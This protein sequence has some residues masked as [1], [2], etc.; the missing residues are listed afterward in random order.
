MTSWVRRSPGAGRRG[1]GG[2]PQQPRG[3]WPNVNSS[4]CGAEEPLQSP[5]VRRKRIH[6]GLKEEEEERKNGRAPVLRVR[7]WGGRASLS[8]SHRSLSIADSQRW[9][10]DAARSRECASTPA[11]LSQAKHF[12]LLCFLFQRPLANRLCQPEPRK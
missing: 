6:P 3:K 11:L 4:I 9:N 2:S 10:R 12:S 5:L 1:T 7:G 8:P